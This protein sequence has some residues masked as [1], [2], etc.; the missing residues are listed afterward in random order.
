MR[1]Q[2]TTGYSVEYKRVNKETMQAVWR[3][4]RGHQVDYELIPLAWLDGFRKDARTSPIVKSVI[5]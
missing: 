3:D 5:E 1:V 4:N 2:Y